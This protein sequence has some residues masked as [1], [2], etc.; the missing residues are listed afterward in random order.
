MLLPKDLIADLEKGTMTKADLGFYE[1]ESSPDM[2][3]P[4]PATR[5]AMEQLY[6]NSAFA[7]AQMSGFYGQSAAQ[8]A[9]DRQHELRV[10][11]QMARTLG[12]TVTF[13]QWRTR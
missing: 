9:N 11:D 8:M 13:P 3:G 10:R 7:S 6:G 5:G 2:A 4:G 12:N 1:T